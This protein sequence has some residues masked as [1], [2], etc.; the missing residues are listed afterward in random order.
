MLTGSLH[1]PRG[2]FDAGT[3]F[4]VIL[5]LQVTCQYL[6][7]Y[8][9]LPSWPQSDTC[10]SHERMVSATSPP[11]FIPGR[12][13]KITPNIDIV[14]SMSLTIS[15]TWL[16]SRP[17]HWT[18]ISRRRNYRRMSPE[19]HETRDTHPPNSFQQQHAV[20]NIRGPAC[21]MC[22]TPTILF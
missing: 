2:P 13:Y 3:V 5:G 20:I 21:Q 17:T 15:A 1:A 7:P 22:F 18:C 19:Q 8:P 4:W 16:R 14:L 10:A 11:D 6:V 9:I 12:H